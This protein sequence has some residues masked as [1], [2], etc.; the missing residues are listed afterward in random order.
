MNARSAAVAALAMLT[1]VLAVSPA[2]AAQSDWIVGARPALIKGDGPGELVAWQQD[3]EETDRVPFGEADTPAGNSFYAAFDPLHQLVYVPTAIGRTDIFAAS[4]LNLIGSMTTIAG[5]RVAGVSP[6][7]S[8]LI[9]VSANQTAAYSTATRKR[10]F[11]ISFGGNAVAFD[12][13]G[14]YAFVGGNQD[15]SIKRIDLAQGKIVGEFPVPRS[16]DLIR[17]HD[18]L[19]SADMKTGVMSVVDLTSGKVTLIRTP[20]VDPQF[21]YKHI[22]AA[23]KGFMQLA[24]DPRHHRVYAAGFSGN[25]LVFDSASGRYLGEVAVDAGP[26][27]GPDK[28]SGLA[29]FDDGEKALVTVENL[30]TAVVVNLDSKQITR[31]FPDAGSN[32][33]LV[34][35]ERS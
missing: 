21:D 11:R 24:A 34:V 2:M 29:I 4:D 13:R 31:V 6:D 15:Q 23:H 17:V 10:L 27:G 9:V 18:R 20:E 35:G 30:D 22:G 33:W 28:L 32:R 1:M 19:Y 26:P 16:G 7:G 5:G 14:Q 12:D 25:I 3:S 8:I